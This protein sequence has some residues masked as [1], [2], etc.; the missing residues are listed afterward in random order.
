MWLWPLTKKRFHLASIRTNSLLERVTASALLALVVWLAA[1]CL[2][3][4][5][6]EIRRL[7][8]KSLRGIGQ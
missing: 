7:L 1:S 8:P 4:L 2:P 6:D 3:E 5:A